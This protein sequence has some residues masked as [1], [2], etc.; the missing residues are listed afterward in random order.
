MI[1]E[2]IIDLET[3]SACCL[4]CVFCPRDRIRRSKTKILMKDVVSLSKVIGPSNVVWLS[5][6]G[7]PLLHCP[8]EEIKVLIKSGAK[9]YSN[10]NAAFLNFPKH[11]YECVANG[12]SFLNVSVYGWD[13]ESYV[14]TSQRDVFDLVK[15]NVRIAAQVIPT[16]RLSF[17]Q[18]ETSPEDVK[19]RLADAFGVDRIRLLREH[20]R[21][22]GPVVPPPKE[23]ALC[24]NYLFISSDGEVL[25]CVNDVEASCPLGKNY[26]MASAMKDKLYP[27]KICS[28]CDCGAR[29]ASFKE[30]FLR[31]VL[32]LDQ[33]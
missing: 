29:F 13:K 12:L 22:D 30:N 15:E 5:G 10:S 28:S 11:L 33:A 19:E 6:L 18:T 31:R 3:C 9:V 27:W 4:S 26:E 1:R 7:E 21:G 16:T 25:S 14:K 17:V 24:K 20:G 8:N 2:T 32:D 23:C